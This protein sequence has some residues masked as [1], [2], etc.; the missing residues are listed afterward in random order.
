MKISGLLA[1]Q[2]VL[3]AGGLEADMLE[4][5]EARQARRCPHFVWHTQIV[6]S[7]GRGTPV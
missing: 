3:E 5:A 7:R 1:G 4:V 6:V 2:Y